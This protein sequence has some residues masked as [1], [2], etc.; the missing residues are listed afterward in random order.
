MDVY[1]TAHAF[2]SSFAGTLMVGGFCCSAENTRYCINYLGGVRVSCSPATLAEPLLCHV[3]C[4]FPSAP[5]GASIMS[6]WLYIYSLAP[7]PRIFYCSE[8]HNADLSLLKFIVRGGGGGG[9][10]CW[11]Q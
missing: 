5:P 4:I 3:G 9:G 6:R 2:S 8:E 10:G 1:F 7:R 11:A